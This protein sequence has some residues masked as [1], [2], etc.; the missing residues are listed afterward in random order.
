MELVVSM[1]C[2]RDLHAETDHVRVSEPVGRRPGVSGAPSVDTYRCQVG[3]V[4]DDPEFLV[5]LADERF[6]R[7]FLKDKRARGGEQDGW[8]SHSF[9]RPRVPYVRMAPLFLLEIQTFL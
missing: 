4:H 7:G 6:L 3:R 5:E 1:R 9:V 2:E 8:G